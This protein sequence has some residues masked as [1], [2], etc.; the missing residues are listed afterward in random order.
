MI[1]PVRRTPGLNCGPAAFRPDPHYS[2]SLAGTNLV[3]TTA[4]RG[5]RHPAALLLTSQVKHTIRPPTP[6]A[7]HGNSEIEFPDRAG[8]DSLTVRV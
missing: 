3:G 2:L 5:G 8:K 1:R 4:N 7:M 6:P